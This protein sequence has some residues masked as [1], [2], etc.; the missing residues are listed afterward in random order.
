MD[1]SQHQRRTYLVARWGLLVACL[2]L[3]VSGA[4]GYIGYQSLSS[5]KDQLA[6]AKLQFEQSGPN[7]SVTKASLSTWGPPVL[8]ETPDEK[9]A[10]ID[11]PAGSNVDAL[12]MQ[13]PYTTYVIARF[14]NVGRLKGALASAGL[15]SPDSTMLSPGKP[16]LCAAT[17]PNQL[18]L[19]SCSFPIW[20]DP[21]QQATVWVPM[22]S[23]LVNA[24]QCDKRG[25][26]TTVTL[27][28]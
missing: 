9:Y 12:H 8:P 23:S 11:A 25:P 22:D 6:E 18:A 14:T 7:I 28:Y 1:D 5:Q 20:L 21:Q 24:L 17:D 26:A 19:V 2:A 10:W 16:D 27:A 3:C 15:S 13:S 4:I